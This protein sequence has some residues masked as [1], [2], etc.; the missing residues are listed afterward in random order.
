M[1]E[2]EFNNRFNAITDECVDKLA[3]AMEANGN[4]EL[5]TFKAK[6][7]VSDLTVKL[8]ELRSEYQRDKAMAGVEMIE[9]KFEGETY[10]YPKSLGRINLKGDQN[11]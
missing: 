11:A 5:F 3:E 2:Q 4:V 10:H 6:L 9:V 1:N 7:Y 8:A